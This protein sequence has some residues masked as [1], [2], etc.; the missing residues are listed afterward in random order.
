MAVRAFQHGL[1][2]VGVGPRRLLQRPLS[3]TV[4]SS[5][6]ARSRRSISSSVVVQ[7]IEAGEWVVV[8]ET[9]RRARVVSKQS[10][11]TSTHVQCSTEV[12]RTGN[13]TTFPPA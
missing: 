10:N 13:S 6:F 12:I 9:G 2:P 8:K 5:P 4:A 7:A 1:R 11:G 3:Q